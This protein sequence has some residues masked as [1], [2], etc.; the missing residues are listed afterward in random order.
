MKST[1]L[2]KTINK[3]PKPVP[4]TVYPLKKYPYPKEV[5]I[6]RA[7]GV[8]AGINAIT[9]KAKEINFYFSI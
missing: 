3:L 4:L 8:R 6:L 5:I 1:I 2:G 7:T 9:N